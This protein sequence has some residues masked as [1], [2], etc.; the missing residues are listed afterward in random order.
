MHS[1]CDTAV[2]FFS[3]T[4]NDEV[5]YKHFHST[6]GKRTNAA[7]ARDLIRHGLF[8][9]RRSGLS[10]IKAL[11]P[12]QVGDSF[13]E[14]LANAIEGVYTQG[15]QRVIIMGNDCPW[16]T[17]GQLAELGHQTSSRK[18]VLG[19]AAD[20]G[21]YLISLDRDAYRR[22]AFLQL[23]WETATLRTTLEIY[24]QRWSGNAA[25]LLPEFRDIDSARAF[26]ALLDDPFVD[27]GL[28]ASLRSI[29]FSPLAHGATPIWVLPAAHAP[30]ARIDRGPPA[31]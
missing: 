5:A 21:V 14:R 3:R 24:A 13:G 22:S 7:I 10:V 29:L 20:G 2:L 27:R 9:A 8:T 31:P 18:V 26:R 23:P 15:F 6:G 11:G 17:P 25:E 19:P 12:D 28:I 30:G 16:I 1:T 4:A